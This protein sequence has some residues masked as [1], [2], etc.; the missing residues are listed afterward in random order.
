MENNKLKEITFKY[1]NSV[2]ELLNKEIINKKAE[3]R[4]K[5]NKKIK[6]DK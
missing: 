1:L 2:E 5:Y 6:H 4:N 3:R